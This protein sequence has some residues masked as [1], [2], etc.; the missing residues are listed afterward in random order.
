MKKIIRLSI[1]L[2]AV[3]FASSCLK[4]EVGGAPEQHEVTI[5]VGPAASKTVLQDNK[6]MWENGDEIAL[7]FTSSEPKTH[8]EKFATSIDGEV[9]ATALFTGTVGGGVYADTR[10]S[11]DVLAVYP[12][13]AIVG[14]KV[15]FTLPSLQFS[16]GSFESGLNLSA[17]NISLSDM[18]DDGHVDDVKF[19]NT[20]AQIRITCPEYATSIKITG[21]SPL[22]GKAPLAFSK[23]DQRLVI[24]TKANWANSDQEKSI[25]LKPNGST[26]FAPDTE[27]NLLILPG[28]HTQL[29]IEMS[30]KYGNIYK[31]TVSKSLSFL[32]SKYYTLN[33]NFEGQLSLKIDEVEEL[34]ETIDE[35]VEN[36][37]GQKDQLKDILSQIQSVSLMT[38]YLDNSVYAAYI[39][40][41][42][43]KLKMDIKLSYL[44]R[45]AEAAKSLLEFCKANDKLSTVFS[46]LASNRKGGFSTLGVKDAYLEDDIL[47]VTFNATNI[48]DSFYDGTSEVIA[49]LEISDG[50]TEIIS[51]FAN[52]VPK[53]GTILNISRTENI[54]ALKGASFSMPYEY[55]AADFNNC[56]VEVVSYT[57]FAT[58]PTVTANSG[59]GYIRANFRESDNPANMSLTLRLTCGEEKDEQTLTFADGGKFNVETSGTVDYIGGE[60]SAKVTENSFGSYTM[61]LIGAG[62]WMYQTNSGVGGL[63]TVDYNSGSART[64][65]LFFTITNGTITY[66]KSVTLE[67][68]SYGTDLTRE[69]FSDGSHLQ[70]NTATVSQP[71]NIVILGDGYQKKDLLKGGK[72]ER[73][74]K[75]TVD[76]FFGVEPYKSFKNRFNVYMVA[77]ESKAEGPR[78]E[79]VSESSH[80]TYFGTWYKGGGNTYVGYTSSSTIQN[81][82]KNT[83]GLSS[84][85]KF[86]RTIV[87]LLVNTSE[88]IGST[89][90]PVMTTGSASTTGD[91]YKSFAIAIL[92]ANSQGT[93]GL[94]RHEAGGHAFGRLGDEYPVDWYTTSLVNERHGYGFYRNVATT[95]SYWSAFTSAGY[96][97]DKVTYDA[98]GSNGIYRS[99]KESGIMWNNNGNF[100]AVSRHAIYERIIKQTQGSSAY[101]W[102]AFLEYDKKNR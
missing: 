26:T 78:L 36:L 62:D 85:A 97:S 86:Y 73:S 50:N 84:D 98:Y 29:L 63:Y 48:W 4:E 13:S 101:S 51:D 42:Y 88:N 19:R 1:Y 91:G 89:D 75:S 2:A 59:S 55:G 15:S 5:S 67:Q 11:D 68:S 46:G 33:P 23:A 38:E 65:S 40:R 31:K 34:L 30:D 100:N 102:S 57:G 9:A 8:V 24:D 80:K 32:A 49:A 41:M 16:D 77:Y 44:I 58:K 43:G 92:A 61:D 18:K 71:L 66:T 53:S 60:V 64:A 35:K 54:P 93:S 90:Y 95:T 27:Y 83:V 70:L 69:Y 82:V 7:V 81:I 76:A 28:T 20:F 6:V 94:V 45:P 47:T 22:A 99:T 17:A 39:Q 56:K 12:H 37:D 10:Y 74:A 14:G 72:F 3:I 25:T 52:L 79:S 96:G 87:I 21:T